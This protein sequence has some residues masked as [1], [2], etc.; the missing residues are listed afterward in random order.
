MAVYRDKSQTPPQWRY[1]CTVQLAG[2]LP[3]DR[4]KLTARGWQIRI[5][6]TP[7]IN[8]RAAGER[9][10]RENIERVQHEAVIATHAPSLL[11]AK[12]TPTLAEWFRGTVSVGS[13][14]EYSGRFWI[15]YVH[16]EKDNRPGTRKE[17]RNVFEHHLEPAIGALRLDAI[18]LGV[19]NN[20]RAELK[21][22]L[23]RNGKPLSDKTRANIMTVLATSLRYAESA[24]VIDRAP[25]I[26]IRAIAPRPIE[27]W[28]FDEYGRLLGSAT[29]EGEPWE[30]AVLLAGEAGLRIGEI[31]A[32][33][34]VDLDLV[35]NTIT[36]S[37]QERQGEVGPPK[38]GKS[39]TVPMTQRLAAHLRSVPRIHTGRVMARGGVPI[40]ENNAQIAIYRI[41]RK[42]GLPQQA[43]HRLR[44]SFATHAAL[45]GVNPLRLQHWLGHSTLNMTL[46]YVHFAEA[47]AWPIPDCVYVAGA[48]HLNP[49]RRLITQL[50][51]RPSIALSV[52][53]D[54]PL[55][56]DSSHAPNP[57]AFRLNVVGNA[58][59]E[60]ATYSV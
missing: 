15:E 42:A 23:K 24:D 46:R 25:P 26:R 58:G 10:E 43:W 28:N 18:D 49:D 9:A 7:T 32:L 6:G 38:G 55:T 20:L 34:W 36:V 54:K 8:I 51:A 13:D 37:R 57:V 12:S 22:K 40:V 47:H 2:P 52:A 39:R 59:I 48:E 45:L 30:S 1:R 56:S 27:C 33:E 5:S 17:K 3:G 4:A 31:V 29:A 53:R 60:P 19:V 14:D 11:T 16:G 50:G 41:C 35:A 21:T 44:H